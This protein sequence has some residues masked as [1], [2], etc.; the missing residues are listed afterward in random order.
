MKLTNK[1]IIGGGLALLS[2]MVMAYLH[3]QAQALYNAC[4]TMAGV[5]VHTIS[6]DKMDFD[7]LMSIKNKSD[8]SF[9]ITNQN[10][11]IYVNK[12]LVATISNPEN[13]TVYSRGISTT[14]IN[15]QFN[16]QDLLQKGLENISKLIKNKDTLVVEIKGTISIGVGFVSYKNYRV[17]EKLLMKD[18]LS[19]TKSNT[20]C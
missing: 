5:V 6:F 13:V 11:L 15:V 18:L 9:N 17:D 3:K 8:I 4:F 16:P 1:V 14:K 10:Y 12:M 20:K 7:V 2:V 19:G